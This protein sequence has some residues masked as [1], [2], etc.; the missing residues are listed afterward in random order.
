MCECPEQF[1]FF[2][3][4]SEMNVDGFSS[5]VAVAVSDVVSDVAV[6]ETEMVPVV[7]E[8]IKVS[9]VDIVNSSFDFTVTRL[10][11]QG[12]DNMTTDFYGLFRSDSSKMVGKPVSSK[13]VPHQTDNIVQ[14]VEAAEKAFDGTFDIRCHFDEGHY[15]TM[16]PS[17][18]ARRE[19]FGTKDSIFPRLIIQA[20]YDGS[21]YRASLGFY[22]DVCRNMAVMKMVAG[23]TVSI[24]HMS[25]LFPKIDSLV[26]TFHNLG[27]SWDKIGN[28]AVAMEAKKV[29][30]TSFLN[31]IYGEPE[32][33]SGRGVTVH[34]NRTEAIFN[35]LLREK[36]ATDRQDI[37]PT[38][39]EVSLWEAYNAVQGYIQ[40]ES[41]R[42]GNPTEMARIVSSFTSPHLARAE[43]IVARLMSA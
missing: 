19:I 14:L 28:Y 42:H 37:D 7:P 35:R 29:R 22:R 2:K 12:P 24:R 25:K 10:P 3:R 21:A 15:V 17:K 40:H 41:S 36:A 34:K 30:L 38:A 8:V 16:A 11:L 31:E 18:A 20:G 4:V 26:E 32:K 5:D 33:D 6:V 1:M 23:S 39:W 9:P 43:S 27:E 13:Y